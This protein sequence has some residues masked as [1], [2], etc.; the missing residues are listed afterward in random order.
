MRR[1]CHFENLNYIDSR[2][3]LLKHS[4]SSGP[5]SLGDCHPPPVP[6]TIQLRRGGA[7]EPPFPSKLSSSPGQFGFGS[8]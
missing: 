6:P 7:K 3:V 8:G 2:D 5:P 1:E 4:I